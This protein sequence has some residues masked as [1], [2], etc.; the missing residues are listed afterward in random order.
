MR[1]LTVLPQALSPF[2]LMFLLSVPLASQAMFA[3]PAPFAHLDRAA[4]QPLTLR[5]PR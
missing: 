1:R 3:P 2:L 4:A 5:S